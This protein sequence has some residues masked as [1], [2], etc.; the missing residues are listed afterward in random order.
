MK[1]H[2][3]N[4]NA[5]L[6]YFNVIVDLVYLSR[7]ME[8]RL[9][10][11]YDTDSESDGEVLDDPFFLE[12]SIEGLSVNDPYRDDPNCEYP[13]QNCQA[14][15]ELSFDKALE[16]YDQDCVI[17]NCHG[18][19]SVMEKGSSCCTNLLKFTGFDNGI[20]LSTTQ[21]SE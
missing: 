11:H 5:H 16:A 7:V 2:R 13:N 8:Y 21:G 1:N 14:P 19:P 12:N 4:S 10:E 3:Y 15:S 17:C 9:D 18:C 6:S 20:V